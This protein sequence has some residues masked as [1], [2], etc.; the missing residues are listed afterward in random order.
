MFGGR[1]VQ[2]TIG[3]PTG[4][5]CACLLADL[6]LFSYKAMLI[7]WLLQRKEREKMPILL[8]QLPLYRWRPIHK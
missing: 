4:N 3:I 2:L 6:L 8:L 7:L 5:I 1:V